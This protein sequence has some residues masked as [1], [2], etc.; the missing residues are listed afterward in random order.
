MRTL[1]FLNQSP[2]PANVHDAK[3]VSHTASSFPSLSP[4]TLANHA[5]PS[6]TLTLT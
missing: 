1:L 5:N 2:F 3:M 4:V 6:S